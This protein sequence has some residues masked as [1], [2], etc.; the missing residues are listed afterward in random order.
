MNQVNL[1]GNLTKDV[2]NFS[3]GQVAKFTLA[4]NKKDKDGN[5]SADFINVVAFSKTAEILLKYTKKG[6]KIGLTGRIQTGS[7]TNK[8]GQIIYTTDVV[9]SSVYLLQKN[10]SPEHKS[11]NEDELPF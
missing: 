1:I 10:E 9:A 11:I 2:L 5:N 8:E 3:D 4:I 6:D 7:Y